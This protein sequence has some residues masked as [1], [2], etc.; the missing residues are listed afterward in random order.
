MEFPQNFQ[1]APYIL[2]TYTTSTYIEMLENANEALYNDD[3]EE[4]EEEGEGVED[5]K[6]VI[7]F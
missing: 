4:E 3:E 5:K 6:V 7:F 1:K 2:S